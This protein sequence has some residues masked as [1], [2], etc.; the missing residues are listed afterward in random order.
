MPRRSRTTSSTGM[1]HVVIRGMDRLCM[2]EQENDYKKYL[3]LLSLYKEE[4]DF[5]LY[6]YC[7]MTNHVHMVIRVNTVSLETIFRKI[8]TH[9]A[10]WFNMKYQR[11]GHLQQERF[12]SEPIEDY[13]Y[14]LTAT[15]YIH[16]NPLKAGLETVPGESYRWSSIH[17]YYNLNDSVTDISFILDMMAHDAFLDY[18][19]TTASD[20]C[21]DID[22]VKKRLPDDVAKEIIQKISNCSSSTD[23]QKL[24][25]LQR[26]EYLSQIHAEGVSTRQLNRLTG[27]SVGIIQRTLNK[28]NKAEGHSSSQSSTPRRKRTVPTVETHPQK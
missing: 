18:N 1:Y 15:R 9:Y 13:T 4:C 5:S 24:P 20:K 11:T 25:V 19:G 10:V 14:L 2:F 3:D 21:L 12:Y 8:N 27:I 23:F 17:D 6:A 26:N 28:K 16:Q 7:L 22:T